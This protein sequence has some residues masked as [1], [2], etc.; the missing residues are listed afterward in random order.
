MTVTLNGTESRETITDAG[1]R[2]SF[3]NVETRGAYT[4]TP[5]RVN[6][7][8]SPP[9]RT[10]SLL[11]IHTEASFTAT[12]NSSGSHLN[13]LDSTGYFVRQQ[14]L[15]FLGREPDQ[16][17]FTFWNNQINSCG[18]D[19]ECM[20]SK[21]IDVSAAFFYSIE[22]QQTGFLVYR[23]N[24]AAYGNLSLDLPVPV[25]LADF[26]PDARKIAQGVVVN[27]DGWQTVMEN[28]QQ[29]FAS[30]FVQRLRFTSAYPDSLTPAEFVDRLFAN[31][32]V[33]P[34]ADDRSAAIN[35]FGSASDTR[36]VPARARAFRD[37]AEN[38][39]LA[40]QEFNRAFVLME[41]FGYLQR[42]PNDPPDG[43]FAGYDY[44]LGKLNRFGGDYRGAEMVKAF[45][46]SSEYRKRF[47]Q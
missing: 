47:G 8:F 26:L 9:S 28:N 1:G 21:R 40:R 10:F 23:M 45:L 17:G 16:N 13:P 12:A 20:E 33:S 19:R 25:T 37:V 31:A 2:Y 38:S 36:D 3:D 39:T 18:A 30:E 29:A 35:E 22:F 32:S 11:G 24:K 27:A 5:A 6:Y 7:S 14:Y 46:M 42:N 15:D 43:D 41:Y 4:V 34:A 44:W